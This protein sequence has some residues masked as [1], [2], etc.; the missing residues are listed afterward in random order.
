MNKQIYNE[1]DFEDY[2]G[3]EIIFEELFDNSYENN[4]YIVEGTLGLWDGP[5]E[6]HYPKVLNSIAEAIYAC[7]DGFNGYINVEEGPYGKLLVHINHHDGNNHLE[8]RQLTK[9]GEEMLNEYRDTSDII[10]RKGATK[11]VK[12]LKNYR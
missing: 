4:K 6:G 2:E 11:N 1:L 5:R 12:F 8:I 3:S 9:L 10:K 7:N